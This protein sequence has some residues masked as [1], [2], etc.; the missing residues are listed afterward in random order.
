M[1]RLHSL[2]PASVSSR[3]EPNVV[4]CSM[5]KL[6]DLIVM[7]AKY[8]LMCAPRLDDM[9]QVRLAGRQ[10]QQKHTYGTWPHSAQLCL[11]MCSCAT[12]VHRD[13]ALTWLNT[14]TQLHVFCRE[15]MSGQQ[16]LH[17]LDKHSKL[18]L[19]SKHTANH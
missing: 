8:Q 4:C 13:C 1:A 16:R 14:G 12:I 2:M 11:L 7:G 6:F 17:M 10:Q 19:Q 3:V 5:D 9:I 18:G 15:C